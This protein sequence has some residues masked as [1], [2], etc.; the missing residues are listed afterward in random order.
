LGC[1]STSD[2]HHCTAPDPQGGGAARAM[3]KVM[4]RA[5]IAAGDVDYVNAHGTSTS[6]GDVAETLAIKQALGERAQQIPVSST[7]STTGHL[8]GA[9]GAL[10]ADIQ[11]LDNWAKELAKVIPDLV[12][13]ESWK[14]QGEGSVRAV[15]GTI[16]VQH[17]REMQEKVDTLLG[18]V[19][20]G[21]IAV[22]TTV[23]TLAARLPS[24]GPQVDWPQEAE[25]QPA[26][27]EARILAALDK[28]CNLDVSERP[29][30]EVIE[31]LSEQG[32]ITVWID[33]KA[34]TD[35]G[36]GT[37]TPVTRSMQRVKLC[38]A[39]KRVLEELDLTYVLRNEAL[40]I[41]SKTE[42]ESMLTTKVYPIFD[43]V[44]SISSESSVG[45]A[46]RL[47]V[48]GIT[49]NDFV[50]RSVPHAGSDFAALID[51]ITAN[52][53]PTTWDE[54]GGPGAIQGFVNS[55]ALVI[56]QT[57]EVHEEIAEYLRALR[58]VAVA[59]R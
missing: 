1:G 38:M 12:E 8:L 42:A 21:R 22:K 23:K 50:R 36:V 27:N 19:F 51:S 9:A 17:S 32:Q 3:Q 49:G 41:T 29:L 6:L 46:A 37:D 24:P 33:H 2:M 53:P 14:P 10:E 43:L 34:L 5:G 30:G 47:N 56:S 58:E 40:V 45:A 25:P 55:G 39:L 15:G 26:A 57:T 16:I 4:R 11:Q 54:V 20:P 59:Q 44:G 7:K 35:A 28:D 52:I 18:E 48:L 31:K 13:P